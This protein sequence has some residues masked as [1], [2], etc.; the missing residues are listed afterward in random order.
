MKPNVIQTLKV[1]YNR[2]NT[3]SLD[4]ESMSSLIIHSHKVCYYILGSALC[5]GFGT[6][7]GHSVPCLI[8][9]CFLPIF[10]SYCTDTDRKANY[11]SRHEQEFKLDVAL[12]GQA[13]LYIGVCEMCYIKE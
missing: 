10:Q 11:I 12:L 7:A 4:I 1:H 9:S 5:E 8:F 3:K 13:Q 6:Q 2:N